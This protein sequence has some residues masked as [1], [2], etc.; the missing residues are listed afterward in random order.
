MSASLA[1]AQSL[2]LT[3]AHLSLDQLSSTLGGLT[4]RGVEF[5]DLYFEHHK[6]ESW[7]LEESIVKSGSFS[8]SSGV[9]VRAISG[10]QTAFAYSGDIGAHSIAEAANTVAAIG[11][12]GQSASVAI[13]GQVR[14]P[15]LY[16]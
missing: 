14:V 12:A 6:S 9:G 4:A 15:S 13:P 2:L 16:T 5:A 8:I 11:R 3:P 1:T 10:E 7:S